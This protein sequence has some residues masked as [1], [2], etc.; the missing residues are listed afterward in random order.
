MLELNQQPS[1]SVCDALP[2]ELKCLSNSETISECQGYNP[3]GSN[4]PITMNPEQTAQ[5][6]PCLSQY[7]DIWPIDDI[8][9]LHLKNASAKWKCQE[10][11]KAAAQ[12]LDSI[13]RIDKAH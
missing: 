4:S 12:V 5:Q 10:W 6:I 11:Q 13:L 7:H 8:L 3:G 1:D 9:Q 2:T